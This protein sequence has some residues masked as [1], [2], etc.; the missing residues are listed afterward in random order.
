MLLRTRSLLPQLA[1]ALTKLGN[2]FRF[3]GRGLAWESQE[4][5]DVVV[6][7]AAI[8]DPADPAKIVAALRS[9]SIGASD[10]ELLAWKQA[11]GRFTIVPAADDADPAASEERVLP[12]EGPVPA[13][14][15]WMWSLYRRR[16]ELAVPDMVRAV[17]RDR[18]LEAIALDAPRP[19]D[20]W[21]RLQLV[22]DTADQ[23]AAGNSTATLREFLTRC[24]HAAEQGATSS[25]RVVPEPDDD[26]V[27]ILTIHA[28]KGLEFPIAIVAGLGQATRHGG[29]HL[30]WSTSESGEAMPMMKLSVKL[31][32]DWEDVE[33][34]ELSYKTI[35]D[36]ETDADGLETERLAYVACTRARDHLAV[37]LFHPQLSKMTQSDGKR[38]IAHDLH[39]AVAVA[40]AAS[41][42]V[43]PGT[44]RVGGVPANAETDSAAMVVSL[45]DMDGWRRERRRVLDA[46]PSSPELRTGRPSGTHTT[47]SPGAADA[48]MT[49]PVEAPGPDDVGDPGRSY[50]P[51]LGRRLG[52]AVHHVAELM[53]PDDGDE[54]LDELEA[55]AAAQYA[56]VDVAAVRSAVGALRLSDAWKR[57][58][59]AS[60]WWRELPMDGSIDGVVMAA[61]AD[62]V[63]QLPDR[64]I[65][66]ADWKADSGTSDDLRL[67]YT[68]QLDAYGRLLEAATGMKVSERIIV[69]VHPRTGVLTEVALGPAVDVSESS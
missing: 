11:G 3:E 68:G 50:D 2:P 18:S 30:R 47:A 39:T 37:S 13:G 4:I 63:W 38:R 32:D 45:A 62:L 54:R 5:A 31:G 21:A 55:T 34:R 8:D 52:S 33:V 14:L 61:I 44:D 1:R 43:I 7:L 48:G 16:F 66:V 64:T 23:F 6:A 25:D 9:R 49:G 20:A 15:A 57:A 53:Q 26:A 65:A 46:R 17:I 35:A 22:V 10:D 36:A 24:V 67:R 40:A 60:H 19:R 69:A 42:S 12:T 59:T 41:R 58:S 27:R 56:V 29:L 28:A 51:T